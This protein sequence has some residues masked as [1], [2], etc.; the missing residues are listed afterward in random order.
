[1][2]SRAVRPA[3]ATV[4]G[5]RQK[6]NLLAT[7]SVVSIF[8]VAKHLGISATGEDGARDVNPRLS[9]APLK[10]FPPP[11]ARQAP[12][13]LPAGPGGAPPSRMSKKDAGKRKP[14]SKARSV[15]TPELRRTGQGS[16]RLHAPATARRHCQSPNA[17]APTRTCWMTGHQGFARL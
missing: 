2:V 4:E 12:A 8:T 10:S 17:C 14:E 1:M 15:S 9:K 11:S 3:D 16:A 6:G 5:G 13:S 7:G